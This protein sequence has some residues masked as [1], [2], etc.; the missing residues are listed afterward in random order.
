MYLLKQPSTFVTCGKGINICTFIGPTLQTC[1]YILYYVL[2]SH[3]C[4]VIAIFS[5]MF[6]FVTH[7]TLSLYF[8][9]KDAP[10]GT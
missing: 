9:K 10:G 4:N 7:V 8:T 3:A 2:L 6:C 5:T 1:Y